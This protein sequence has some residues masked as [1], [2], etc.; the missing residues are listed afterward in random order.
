MLKLLIVCV[1]IIV[2]IEILS[3]KEKVEDIHKDKIMYDKN[4][5]INKRTKE[6]IEKMNKEMKDRTCPKCNKYNPNN[7]DGRETE[8]QGIVEIYYVCFECKE[9]GATWKIKTGVGQR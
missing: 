6:Q 3:K 1:T 2:V 4:V 5:V 9:C 8:K 7:Y